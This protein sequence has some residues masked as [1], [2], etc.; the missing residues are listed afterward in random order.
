MISAAQRRFVPMVIGID[1]NPDRHQI[2]ISD[3]HRWNTHRS[4]WT[5]R[6]SSYGDVLLVELA[7]CK[8]GEKMYIRRDRCG[9]NY[10]MCSD[11]HSHPLTFDRKREQSN[12][13]RAPYLK[14]ED[15][16]HR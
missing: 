4:N 6:T 8:C 11:R 2:G 12:R 16:D 13:C 1:R 9:I 7:R 5:K 14:I 3:R 15:T 10:Y